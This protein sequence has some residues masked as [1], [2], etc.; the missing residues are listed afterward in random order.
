VLA[1]VS[2]RTTIA[3]DLLTKSRSASI[4]VSSPRLSL[5]KLA[6]ADLHMGDTMTDT[7]HSFTT[8]HGDNTLSEVPS[9][10]VGCTSRARAPTTRP[11]DPIMVRGEVPTSGT[12]TASDTRGLSDC[13]EPD[14][15]RRQSW[16]S[17]PSRRPSS[18]TSAVD[19]RPSPCGRAGRAH[20]C[21]R[22]R[23]NRIFSRRGARGV[24]SAI[25][26]LASTSPHRP[27]RPHQVHQPLHRTGTEWVPCR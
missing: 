9:A 11:R 17:R 8:V 13:S 10:P 21:P 2:A 4:P 22:R 19:L 12:S 20:R 24:E 23:L 18:P 5:L 15:P 3:L 16:P 14:R 6:K 26:C 27:T 7:E 25:S 1:E